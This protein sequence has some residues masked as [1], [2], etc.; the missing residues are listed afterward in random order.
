MIV[1]PVAPKTDQAIP[2]GYTPYYTPEAEALIISQLEAIQADRG[3]T[4]C[5]TLLEY[6]ANLGKDV[7]AGFKEANDAAL[8]VADKNYPTGVFPTKPESH[9]WQRF[10][11]DKILGHAQLIICDFK[12]GT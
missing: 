11:W 6:D 8:K 2:K 3:T 4:S 12:P 9:L 1:T 10:V 5:E 7:F